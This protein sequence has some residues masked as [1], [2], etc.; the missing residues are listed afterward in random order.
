MLLPEMHP[1]HAAH[2]LRTLVLDVDDVLVRSTWSRG[3]G[4]KTF[5]RPGASDFLDV[6]ARHF[7]LVT[8]SNRTHTYVDPIL[9]RVDPGMLRADG[10]VVA[11]RLYKNACRMVD[12]L[13]VRDLSRLNRDLRRTL[14]IVSESNKHTV[15]QQ[16]NVLVIPD[17]EDMNPDDRTLLDILPLL[18]ILSK[19][20]RH[21]PRRPPIRR[22]AC[23]LRE[24]PLRCGRAMQANSVRACIGSCSTNAPMPH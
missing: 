14:F 2:A 21:G 3:V 24:G 7:E 22:H 20:V 5:K 16:E 13:H 15:A 8:F 1:V 11:Y 19:Q 17:W 4:W 18:E 6:L 12:N 23:V 9:N 10:P